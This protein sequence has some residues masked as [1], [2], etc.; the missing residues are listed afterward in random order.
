MT[1][2]NRILVATDFSEQADKAFGAA[3]ALAER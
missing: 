1:G 2:P 3:L